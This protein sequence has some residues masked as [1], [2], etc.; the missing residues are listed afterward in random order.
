MIS[1]VVYLLRIFKMF[2]R[3]MNNPVLDVAVQNEVPRAT[4]GP[5]F[6]HPCL[7]ILKILGICLRRFSNRWHFYQQ[8]YSCTF[9]QN[10]ANTFIYV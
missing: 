2:H 1:A 6:L 7:K 3:R 8:C 10:H 9:R 4:R 5:G